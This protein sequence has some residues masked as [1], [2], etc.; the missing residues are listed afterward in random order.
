LHFGEFVVYCIISDRYAHYSAFIG[1]F[2]F[3]MLPHVSQ[4]IIP[5]GMERLMHFELLNYNID[6]LMSLKYHVNV[7]YVQFVHV[8]YLVF[9]YVL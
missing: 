3:C 5:N 9:V 6:M 4:V 7:I 2:V 8:S 1:L